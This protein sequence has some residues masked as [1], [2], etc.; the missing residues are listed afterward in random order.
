M[1][2]SALSPSCPLVAFKARYKMPISTFRTMPDRCAH[3]YWDTGASHPGARGESPQ[4][5]PT[6]MIVTENELIP[7]PEQGASHK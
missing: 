6:P 5:L 2:T 7:A 1:E 3:A 4:H